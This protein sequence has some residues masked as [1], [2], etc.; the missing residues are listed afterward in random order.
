MTILEKHIERVFR[1]KLTNL[2]LFQFNIVT[3]VMKLRILIRINILS[4]VVGILHFL[5][6]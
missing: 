1:L 6:I 2:S 3:F 4:K 5:I